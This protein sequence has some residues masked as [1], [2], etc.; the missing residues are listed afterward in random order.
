[1][2]QFFTLVIAGLMMMPSFGQNSG[3]N[4]QLLV[5]NMRYLQSAKTGSLTNRPAENGR[6]RPP[7]FSNQAELR[8]KNTLA[9]MQ[10]MDSYIYQEYDAETELWVNRSMDEFT[11]DANGNNTSDIFYTWNPETELYDKTGKQ[12]FYY[13]N[14]HLAEQL[15]FEWDAVNN[16]WVEYFRW[17]FNYNEDGYMTL[18]NSY[19]WD[20][21]GWVLAG[22]DERT[23]DDNGNMILQITA[24]WD[25]TE[26]VWINDSKTENTYNANGSMDVSTQFTWDFMSNGWVNSYM[27]EYTYDIGGLLVLFTTS[28]WET[29]ASEW[30]YEFQNEYVYDENM[31]IVMSR[32][33]SW[34]GSQWFYAWRSELSYNNA[35]SYNE[36]LLPWFF[37]EFSGEFQHM[38]TE[39]TEYGFDGLAFVLTT[40]SEFNYSQV[41]LTGIVENETVRTNIYP[42]PADGQVN[43]IWADNHPTLE[44]GVF[45]VNG[46][47][48]L[49][50]QV[51]NNSAV[52]VDRLAPGLYFYKLADNNLTVSAGKLSVR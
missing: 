38:L 44:L 35:Y 40:R 30:V 10:Q 5:D 3:K 25:E 12:E 49:S 39:I 20:G 42:Q 47:M 22:R 16:L 1:M 28:V 32:E 9:L 14:G 4:R 26:D 23:Y 50:Q 46:K 13:E 48:V 21:S 29:I 45:D 24:W 2:K 37:V 6:V 51:G 15:Y 7:S 8:H 33:Y 17:Q 31:N 19:F 52:A 18:S 11:Y 36:L 27:D 41:D 43:F 34:D